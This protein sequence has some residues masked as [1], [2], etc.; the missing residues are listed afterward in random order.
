MNLISRRYQYN[1]STFFKLIISIDSIG[2]VKLLFI[3]PYINFI[4]QRSRLWFFHLICRSGLASGKPILVTWSRNWVEV[5]TPRSN[6]WAK[7][8]A[9]AKNKLFVALE[10]Y[11]VRRSNTYYNLTNLRPRES[12][13]LGKHVG[14]KKKIQVC[15]KKIFK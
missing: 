14:V 7:A 15:K 12:K 8:W 11:Y 4:F 1:Y 5:W 3:S 6:R 9:T 13:G 10:D 2:S